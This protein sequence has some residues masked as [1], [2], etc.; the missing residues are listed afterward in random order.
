MTGQASSDFRIKILVAH[1]DGRRQKF[2]VTF[3]ERKSLRIDQRYIGLPLTLK[4]DFIPGAIL[5]RP[6]TGHTMTVEG[7]TTAEHTLKVNDKLS[8]DQYAIEF[9]ELPEPLPM[10]EATRFI[11]LSSLNDVSE[12]T[13]VVSARL[14]HPETATEQTQTPVAPPR[15]NTGVANSIPDLDDST[16]II[17]RLQVPGGPSGVNPYANLQPAMPSRVPEAVPTLPNAVEPEEPIPEGADRRVGRKQIALALAALG[18]IGG[19]FVS[20]H[21]LKD[22]GVETA[23]SIHQS[24][25]DFAAANPSSTSPQMRPMQIGTES[26]PTK[27]AEVP[28]KS[29][30]TPPVPAPAPAAA[31]AHVPDRMASIPAP[32]NLG[33]DS[34]LGG[35]TSPTDSPFDDK[36]GF[37]VM[38][39]D[40]F[41]DAIDSGNEAK[42]KSLV[43]KRVVDVNLSRRKGYAALHVAAARGDLSIVKLLLKYKADPNVIDQSGATPLMWA[44]FRRHKPVAAFLSTKTDLRI[45]RQG[46]ETAFAMAKR[47]ELTPYY[48]FLTPPKPPKT[49]AAAASAKK[50][51]GKQRLPSALP[52]KKKKK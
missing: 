8:V 15:V 13:V 45:E 43:E 5:C 42:I 48:A 40:A 22:L 41:F 44:V 34:P 2:L 12:S 18:L 39:V 31:P 17:R 36:S 30:E 9:L 35:K 25:D 46:G 51:T 3:P 47:L 23:E 16:G 32:Q 49:A 20:R 37:D 10:E 29:A 50:M 21:L 28:V 33:G 1:P 38:A 7:K 19:L 27:V 4:I 6:G 24:M 26:A 52:E 11:S 14:E